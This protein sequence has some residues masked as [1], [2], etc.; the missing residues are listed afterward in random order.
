MKL[1][2]KQGIIKYLLIFWIIY[3]YLFN[4]NL[5][6]KNNVECFPR[7]IIRKNDIIKK[8]NNTQKIREFKGSI[9]EKS[10][11]DVWKIVKNLKHSNKKQNTILASFIWEYNLKNVLE[12]GV[13]HG[14][15]TS[16]MKFEPHPL[17]ISIFATRSR[18]SQ[19]L[20]LFF[21]DPSKSSR[22]LL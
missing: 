2:D 14:K 17:N 10:F 7:N 13:K 5:Y 1:Y 19:R 12:M 8:I 15:A 16:L 3:M 22:R 21:K 6:N 9:A 4:F 11:N 20:S 18:C